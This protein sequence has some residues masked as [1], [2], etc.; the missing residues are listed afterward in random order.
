MPEPP[1]TYTYAQLA[2]RIGDELGVTPSPGALRA[3]RA[4]DQ[5]TLGTRPRARPRITAAMPPPLEA[6]KATAPARFDVEA[7]EA[8]LA[9]HPWRVHAK[10][11]AAYRAALA[12][13]ATTDQ[14]VAQALV[15]GLSWA[16]IAQG[17]RE[18]RGDQRGVQGIFKALRHLGPDART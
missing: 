10:N 15:D 11:L 16:A 6:A 5:R 3:A 14:A 17:L 7:V 2:Q 12:T 18:V 13:G 8:W 9:A 1:R 4:E